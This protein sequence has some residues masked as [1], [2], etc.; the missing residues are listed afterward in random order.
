MTLLG[1]PFDTLLSNALKDTFHFTLRM[2]SKQER[3]SFSLE[4]ALEMYL[5]VNQSV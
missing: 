3:V 1:F 2:F 5:K 4:K